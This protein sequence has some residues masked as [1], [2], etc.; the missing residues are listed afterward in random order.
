MSQPKPSNL[1]NLAT[2]LSGLVAQVSD[3]D[4]RFA[5]VVIDFKNPNTA[6]LTLFELNKRLCHKLL[7]L[8]NSSPISDARP[9]KSEN[10]D[11][12]TLL[13]LKDEE[14]KRV[15]ADLAA[16]NA[17]LDE[18]ARKIKL[19]NCKEE[20]RIRRVSSGT[21]KKPAPTAPTKK[22]EASPY[23]EISKYR[24]LVDSGKLLENFNGEVT[25]YIDAQT[26]RI[27]DTQRRL[28]EAENR[29]RTTEHSV[30][31]T[32]PSRTQSALG[33]YAEK[34][35]SLLISD[36]KEQVS[37]YKEQIKILS[38]Q[39]RPQRNVS[40][41]TP[42][43]KAQLE[44]IN[45]LFATQD[46]E[47]AADRWKEAEYLEFD[48]ESYDRS[49]QCLRE[50]VMIRDAQL[51]ELDLQLNDSRL[52][53]EK[54]SAELKDRDHELSMINKSQRDQ[55]KRNVNAEYEA[56]SLHAKVDYLTETLNTRE[57]HIKS[58]LTDCSA[59]QQIK[60]KNEVR[61]RVLENE[62]K[63]SQGT[64]E[65]ERIRILTTT[66]RSKDEEIL[67]LLGRIE[68]YEAAGSACYDAEGLSKECER[69]R[70]LV[71]DKE[72]LIDHLQKKSDGGVRPIQLSSRLSSERTQ[73][74]SGE[75]K[76]K[77]S[78]VKLEE[79]RRV[80]SA[81][82]AEIA[83]LKEKTLEI[84][85][86]LS[87]T[88]HKL[89]DR[90]T[91]FTTAS[92]Q[93]PHFRS[94][95]VDLGKLNPNLPDREKLN[96]E[97]AALKNALEESQARCSFLE[98]QL[99]DANST[100]ALHN[101]TA[102]STVRKSA[103]DSSPITPDTADLSAV[104]RLTLP[105][106]YYANA[107]PDKSE[108]MPE[109]CMDSEN[110]HSGSSYTRSKADNSPKPSQR[111]EQMT[112]TKHEY[113]D[114]Q[115][116]LK[117]YKEA[118]R[119]SQL[120]EK[121]KE[122]RELF[123][124]VERLTQRLK[125]TDEK[126]EVGNLKSDLIELQASLDE[127]EREIAQSYI[128]KDLVED[129][130]VMLEPVEID[131]ITDFDQ[132]DYPSRI[133]RA[134][135]R[136]KF[137]EDSSWVKKDQ[138]VPKTQ[139]E[140]T[141]TKRELVRQE[142]L[143]E[144][145]KQIIEIKEKT[146][147]DSEAKLKL[148]ALR[149]YAI[150]AAFEFYVASASASSE[151]LASARL[152]RGGADG[153]EAREHGNSRSE[154]L[155]GRLNQDLW[156]SLQILHIM[157]ATFIEQ[158]CF[159]GGRDFLKSLKIPSQRK[160]QPGSTDSYDSPTAFA[161]YELEHL[162]GLISEVFEGCLLEYAGTRSSIEATPALKADLAKF[163]PYIR[164]V[165]LQ[166]RSGGQTLRHQLNSVKALE[167]LLRYQTNKPTKGKPDAAF[168]TLLEAKDLEIVRLRRMNSDLQQELEHSSKG[169]KG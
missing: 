29:A 87:E 57:A 156:L 160:E 41:V 84:Q 89:A 16:A 109:D 36:L 79:A 28:K 6:L 11:L 70:A 86:Q 22:S 153:E 141:S 72:L 114:L 8:D 127:K 103:K 142:Q 169:A 32:M 131:L 168:T 30:S 97:L 65:S 1:H 21:V 63:A 120:R 163:E 9:S 104:D 164:K 98:E 94:T 145:L 25:S 34:S 31:T 101:S 12:I 18:V 92:M 107:R 100:I 110:P 166:V 77:E 78:Q 23:L 39:T 143:L 75:I 116:E 17:K 14:L 136:F 124:S 147:K 155:Q 37:L 126:D 45:D 122:I 152:D 115:R 134:I 69:L 49:F 2:E 83:E 73:I 118:M 132:T 67:K 165:I 161:D 44:V 66:V 81:K 88:R 137:S 129:L 64:T 144:S 162:Y 123:D 24:E 58:L 157:T 56:A 82:D 148:N 151:N 128:R 54:F 95:S 20:T 35:E 167:N 99:T 91:Y 42:R 62:L 74:E 13:K 139:G 90:Q 146:L 119:T 102:S 4:P 117:Q 80:V 149:S 60:A 26:Q 159:A 47:L 48:G 46:I 138:Q 5:S 113:E 52:L 50:I 3:I 71:N 27:E 158:S 106:R 51:I 59:L 10:A 108:Q 43:K 55:P 133:Q 85:R 19:R 93:S 130:L 68:E 135:S 111:A 96:G 105:R 125:D 7:E 38:S 33:C 76:L 121:D 154:D 112:Y 61:L 15:K 53:L 40:H 150:R 140:L